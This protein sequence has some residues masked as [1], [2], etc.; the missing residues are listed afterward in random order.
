M[1][2]LHFKGYLPSEEEAV[3]GEASAYGHG[4]DWT[5]YHFQCQ[6]IGEISHKKSCHRQQPYGAIEEPGWRSFLAKHLQIQT[7]ETHQMDI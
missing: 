4:I 7:R 3:K 1:T 5:K 2:V 6:P